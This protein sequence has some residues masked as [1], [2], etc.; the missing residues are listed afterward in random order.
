MEIDGNFFN[1]LSVGESSKRANMLI[2]KSLGGVIFIDEAYALLSN[3]GGQ[4]VIATIVKAM[5]D[6]RDEIVFIFAGY[7]KEMEKLVRSN[8]GIESRIKYHLHFEEY[9]LGEL[10]QIFK[11]MAHEKNL[12]VSE[13]LLDAFSNEIMYK[14]SQP[15]F[16][17]ARTVRNMLD[18]IIDKHAVNLRNGSIPEAD[19][20]KLK[21]CDF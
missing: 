5:E 3:G 2:T 15:D 16:G 13:K 19:R 14:K 4:E 8:P 1:G 20:Y 9:N 17:N 18:T 6:H 10:K 21:A 7:E 12:L 11:E